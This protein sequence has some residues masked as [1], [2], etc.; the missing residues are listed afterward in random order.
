MGAVGVGRAEGMGRGSELLA[1]GGW[2][3]GGDEKN[4]AAGRA[5]AKL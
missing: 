4:A 3:G 1:V 5:G 2:E